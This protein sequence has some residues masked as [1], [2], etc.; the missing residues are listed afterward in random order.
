MKELKAMCETAGF[1]KVQ[2]Y[3]RGNVVFES[4]YTERQVKAALEARLKGFVASV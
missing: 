1:G 3:A 2:T 4:D